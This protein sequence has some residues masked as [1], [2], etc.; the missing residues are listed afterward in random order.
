ME[1][2]TSPASATAYVS[3]SFSPKVEWP[4]DRVLRCCSL[5]N[6]LRSL[7][8]DGSALI[9]ADSLRTNGWKMLVEMAEMLGTSMRIESW[10]HRIGMHANKYIDI[11]TYAAMIS[12]DWPWIYLDTCSHQPR[13]SKLPTVTSSWNGA[14]STSL[15]CHKRMIGL[16][17]SL[18]QQ[19]SGYVPK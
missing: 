9:K 16:G 5:P 2:V 15:P 4:K 6:S 7:L 17:L 11:S 10:W 3:W 18:P 13:K 1:W 14:M 12:H 19:P 8:D